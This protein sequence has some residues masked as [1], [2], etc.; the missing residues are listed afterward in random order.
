MLC[1]RMLVRS[2]GGERP[3]L[4]VLLLLAL[5]KPRL[6]RKVRHLAAAAATVA[7]VGDGVEALL[8]LANLN[9]GV[10]V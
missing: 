3:V 2:P 10:T 6:D 8:L 9:C 1:S 4:L 7:A 5:I